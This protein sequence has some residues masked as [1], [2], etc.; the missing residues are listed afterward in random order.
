MRPVVE[1]SRFQMMVT[2][3]ILINALVVGMETY[4]QFSASYGS[5]LPVIDIL[6]LLIFTVELVMRF[7]ASR[8]AGEFIRNPW[9]MFD[10]IVVGAGYFPATT[11]VSILRL[12]RLLRILRAVTVVPG[13][14]RV[15]SAL[16]RS[17]PSMGYVSLLLALIVYVYGALGTYFF[18]GIAPAY[19]GT[20]H[21]SILTLFTILTLEGWVGVMNSVGATA[22]FAWLYF[23][24]FILFGTYMALNLFIGVIVTNM[25]STAKDKKGNAASNEENY[26]KEMRR[27]LARIEAR[28]ERLDSRK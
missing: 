16:I 21:Q 14:R 13:L 5:I 26:L 2:G 1:S 28:L 17:L 3:V 4:R 24:T 7:L 19:F 20:L 11:F 8:S 6:T 27:S 10:V 25:Q 18:S 12:F 15:V 23:I 9:N 22:P